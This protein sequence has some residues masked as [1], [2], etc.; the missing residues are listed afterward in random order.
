MCSR[1]LSP[2]RL[3]QPSLPIAL[4][5]PRRLQ[6]RLWVLG[7]VRKS[8]LGACGWGRR[9]EV[10]ETGHVRTRAAT[11]GFPQLHE[12]TW[13]C[14]SFL[15]ALHPFLFSGEGTLT[16]QTLGGLLS[17]LCRCGSDGHCC[18]RREIE[19]HSAHREALGP[20]QA[21]P[22]APVHRTSP[23]AGQSEPSRVFVCWRELVGLCRG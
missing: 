14:P 9:A 22:S 13:R 2:S 5:K 10:T 4:V 1:S 11:W 18:F 8:G 17:A 19:P 3:I 7:K 21:N 23:A 16:P 6:A 20:G 12:V 15:S